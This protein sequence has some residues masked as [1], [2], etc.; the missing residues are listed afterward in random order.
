MQIYANLCTCTR[1][2]A[3]LADVGVKLGAVAVRPHIVAA[4][5]HHNALV[6][7]VVRLPLCQH[8]KSVPVRVQKVVTFNGHTYESNC[9][10]RKAINK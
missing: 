10:S 2:R 5:L 9:V 8:S 1:I 4:W 7:N 3:S 6:V